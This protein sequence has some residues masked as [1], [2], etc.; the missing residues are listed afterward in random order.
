[1]G[2][3]WHQQQQMRPYG[4]GAALSWTLHGGESGRR[5][6]QPKA[7]SSI[8]ASVEDQLIT[9]VFVFAFFFFYFSNK[10]MSPTVPVAFPRGSSLL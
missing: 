9:S 3:Q 7:A 6:V 10:V 8:K 5:P 4:C 2:P 1:M